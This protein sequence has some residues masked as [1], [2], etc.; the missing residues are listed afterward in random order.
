MLKTINQQ[1]QSTWHQQCWN[2][3]SC[4]HWF[5]LWRAVCPSLDSLAY[6]LT[7]RNRPSQFSP[8][9]QP[10]HKTT[11]KF[12]TSR[13]QQAWRMGKNEVALFCFLLS[14]IE[15]SPKT[16]H[17]NSLAMVQLSPMNMKNFPQ[18]AGMQQTHT[19]H[20]MAL[21]WPRALVI[22]H[23]LHPLDWPAEQWIST[24]HIVCLSPYS[25]ASPASWG[26]ASTS[27][28]SELEHHQTNATGK[29]CISQ[30]EHQSL[31]EDCALVFERSLPQ[32]SEP[33]VPSWRAIRLLV[34]FLSSWCEAES[35]LQ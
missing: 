25:I 33:T 13:S 11:L 4:T 22:S 28:R 16:S 6:V 20:A 10:F 18:L 34:N 31:F 24:C 2:C 15:L 30:L 29:N 9:L 26:F 8:S 21:N 7:Q 5:I 12:I 17:I 14:F 32:N 3:S 1:F 27:A 19:S 23:S 35:Q